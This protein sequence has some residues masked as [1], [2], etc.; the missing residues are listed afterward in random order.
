MI[1]RIL[2]LIALAV[3]VLDLPAQVSKGGQPI[4]P[5]TIVLAGTEVPTVALGPLQGAEAEEAVSNAQFRYGV[6]RMVAVDVTSAGRWDVLS[7][8]SRL[9]RMRLHSAGAI[10]LSVQ[11]DA[12]E[13]SEGATVFL[14]NEDGST[15]IGS[16]DNSNRGPD[17]SMATQVLPGDAVTIEYRVPAGVPRGALHVSSIT[18][19]IIDVFREL[20]ST[21]DR[22]YNPGYQSAACQINVNCPV[23]SAW[24]AQK[25]SV[26]MF[27]RPDGAGCTA[28]LINNT[29]VPGRPYVHLAF[30][31]LVE[32]TMNQWVFYF[33]YESPGCVGTSG[34][35]TQTLTGVSM[36]AN[37]ILDDFVLAELNTPPPASYNVYYAG[38]DRSGNVPQTVTVLEHPL[39]DVKKIAF[40]NNP[41]T[42]SMDE[43]VH[44]WRAFW[45]NG[46]TEWGASGAPCFD[47]NKRFIGHVV[48]GNMACSE[49]QTVPAETL[50]SELDRRLPH[51]T[52][53]GTGWIRPS[54]DGARRL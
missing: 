39:Y 30:H 43:Y 38:W 17:G 33:N 37:Y 24:Q 16:F 45:D 25:R 52:P 49:S 23:A 7:D 6:Q 10:M 21:E 54:G 27:L 35:T 3:L 14:Y 5:R 51:R 28:N 26:V 34:P 4:G 31:C 18:H 32:S 13:M 46:I 20:R 48:S 44:T 15:V 9:C 50:F 42:S 1:H 19:C 47:Q 22:D 29:A 8:G 36:V 11:F 40:D 2:P 12:W 53:T 41:A